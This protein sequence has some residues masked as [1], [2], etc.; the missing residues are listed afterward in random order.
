MLD[1]QYRMH[2]DISWFPNKAFYDSQLKD[3]TAGGNGVVKCGL[4]PPK[5]AFTRNAEAGSD[6]T[7]TFLHHWGLEKARANSV[8][9][10]SEAKIIYD[11]VVD[12]LAQNPVCDECCSKIILLTTFFESG[13][14]RERYWRYIAVCRTNITYHE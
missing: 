11:V 2:P 10:E 4:E 14:Q 3:G 5:S 9:N 8:E 7:V 1:T 13:T 6:R 12:L